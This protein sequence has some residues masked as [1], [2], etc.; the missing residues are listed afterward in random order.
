MANIFKAK[1]I[2][3]HITSNENPNKPHVKLRGLY[4]A[5]TYRPLYFNEYTLN[6]TQI[7][8]SNA[9]NVAYYTETSDNGY[10]GV[11]QLVDVNI[12]DPTVV[13]YTTTSDFGYDDDGTSDGL[14]KFSGFSIGETDIISFTSITDPSYE[15]YDGIVKLSQFAIDELQLLDL[16]IIDLSQPPGQP[17]LNIRSISTVSATVT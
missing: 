14:V 10:D 5:G 16:P 1:E 12:D 3:K 9:S 15:E 2:Y 13:E 6:L 8:G 17:V 4:V 7:G 11:V